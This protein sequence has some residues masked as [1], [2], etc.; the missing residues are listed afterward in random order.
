MKRSET[1]RKQVVDYVRQ[2][3]CRHGVS[4][5]TMDDIARGMRVSKRTLY[6]LFP[7][8][9]CLIRLCLSDIANE[10][11]GSLPDREDRSAAA[12][13]QTLFQT[14]NCYI[15]LLHTLG[16]TLLTD[17][18]PDEEYHSFIEWELG[19][20]K[21]QLL[22]AFN[23]CQAHNCLLPF[24]ETVT[25]VENLTRILFEQCRQGVVSY[26]EQR[27]LSNV[28]LRGF[29]RQEEI[30]YIDAYLASKQRPV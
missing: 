9:T 15:R 26:T 18:L 21:Q 1:A 13:V 16:S 2:E 25:I 29:F 23:Q 6:Q 19:F 30:S 28:L 24:V 5:L 27:M 7:Q 3:I 8:K 10:A 11:R 17:L 20:W 12:S 22:D 4:K 14:L